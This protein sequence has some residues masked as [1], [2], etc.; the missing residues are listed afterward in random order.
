MAATK[1]KPKWAEMLGGPAAETDTA[2]DAEPKAPPTTVL[3]HTVVGNPGNPRAASDY[4]DADDEFRDLKASMQ[5]V[6]QLQPAVAMSRATFCRSRPEYADAVPT[7]AEWVVILGNRRLHAARELGWT[8]FEIR[9]KDHLADEGDDKVDEAVV[10][11]N[12]HR[13]NIAPY[14]E[15]VF[16]QRMLERHGSQEKVADRIGKSQMYVS[17]RLALLNLTPEVRDVVDSKQI[18]VKAAE[19]IAKLKDPEEQKARV[20]EELEKAAQ[21]KVRKPRPV[22]NPVLKAGTEKGPDGGTNWATPEHFGHTFLGGPPV[23]QARTRRKDPAEVWPAK[24]QLSVVGDTAA[25]DKA[26]GETDGGTGSEAAVTT[27]AAPGEGQ[28]GAL[29]MEQ[30]LLELDDR[31]RS[32]LLVRYIQATGR[33]EALATDLARATR[34]ENRQEVAALLAGAA[35]LLRKSS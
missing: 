8:K 23:P 35:E 11:E 25:D 6:G 26:R 31:Q 22:Q 21:P 12:I 29:I 10:I 9:V 4:T 13:K 5:T 20:A 24:P 30:L 19:Q 16:L 14:Q 15:A 33:P 2:A 1:P 3:M 7:D 32:R 34:P 18:R 28:D 17:N 27:I